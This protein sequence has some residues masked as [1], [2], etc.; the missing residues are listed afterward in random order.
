MGAF[1]LALGST[2]EEIDMLSAGDSTNQRGEPAED[3]G[4]RWQLCHICFFWQLNQEAMRK[5]RRTE[6]HKKRVARVKRFFRIWARV[7]H[8][9]RS[10][11]VINEDVPVTNLRRRRCQCMCLC[12]HR[13]GRLAPC[14][15]CRRE[16]GSCCLT[17]V[18]TDGYKHCHLC[19]LPSPPEPEPEPTDPSLT[20]AS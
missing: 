16:C 18:C 3:L 8:N 5:H 2:R 11:E 12:A 15:E 20:R 1:R 14:S 13:P 6:Y 9:R 17:L 4:E 7:C 10:D 19:G